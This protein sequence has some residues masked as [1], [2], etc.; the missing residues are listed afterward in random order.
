M[1]PLFHWLILSLLLSAA[2]CA[3]SG[4]FKPFFLIGGLL[5]LLLTL[6]LA[7]YL[8]LTHREA[9]LTRLGG[10]FILY[11]FWL[12]KEMLFSGLTVARSILSPEP[13]MQP[14]FR[15]IKAPYPDGFRTAVLANSITLTPGTVSVLVNDK[16]DEI[17]VHALDA[18]GLDDLSSGRMADVVAHL[19]EG[20][21]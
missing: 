2:W 10:R 18:S 16:G 21:R 8:R 6:I 19:P 17:L 14:G 1:R 15:W 13:A 7:R 11:Q 4:L 5:A 20:G 3:W 12:L 9:S